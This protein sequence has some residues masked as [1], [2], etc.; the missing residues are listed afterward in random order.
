MTE[1]AKVIN[2]TLANCQNPTSVRLFPCSI[3][4]ILCGHTR[5]QM[6]KK[7]CCEICLKHI[8]HSPCELHACHEAMLH[9]A[10]PVKGFSMFQNIL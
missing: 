3:D 9:H 8:Y 6:E 1:A 2:T 7:I 5:R 4:L 10:G